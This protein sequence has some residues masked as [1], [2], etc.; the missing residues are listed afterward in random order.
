MT[1]DSKSISS[2]SS[3]SPGIKGS[4]AVNEPSGNIVP[5][6]QSQ[7][8]DFISFLKG[9]LSFTGD[10]SSLTCP[11][12]LLNGIS[13]LEYGALERLSPVLAEITKAADSEE[14][15]KLVARWFV[16][17]LYGSFNK[18]VAESNSG[19]KKPFNPILGEHF[20]H[21]YGKTKFICE[22]V[23]HHPPVSA[24]Y[25]ENAKA[26]IYGSGH[27]SQKSKFKSTT[28]KV[29]QEG[30]VTLRMKNT[31]E[32]YSLSLPN[33][34][35][36]SILTGKPFLE[37]SSNTFIRSSKGYTAEFQWHTKPWLYGEYHK[38]DG[39]IYKDLAPTFVQDGPGQEQL[40]VLK[41][42][43][44]GESRAVNVRT[45][46]EDVLFDPLDEQSEL[47]SRK[48][49]HAVSDAL[50]RGDYDTASK[51]K[52][53]IEEAQRAVRKQRADTNQKWEP[54]RRC[55]P[56]VRDSYKYLYPAKDSI[57]TGSWVYKNSPHMVGKSEVASAS[58]S[59]TQT[60]SDAFS[61]A[62][63]SVVYP[64]TYTPDFF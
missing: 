15:M 33:L 34:N 62:A 19:E 9:V 11:S 4:T 39:K 45:R 20:L 14:R 2:S 61:T 40:Y 13:L 47:E 35:I 55:E 27:F 52:T 29:V 8:S 46:Q 23:S 54:R 24:I 32:V 25:F 6:S 63:G 7:S 51:E 50:A 57:G 10:L 31:D 21:Q 58:A 42:K 30:R 28:M 64:H 37:M 36:C 56:A 3:G 5:A 1:S 44:V 49:W 16:S 43:W 59:G 18:R 26:G 12:F 53:A 22:Q 17:T 38:F 60:P 41:G 48:V